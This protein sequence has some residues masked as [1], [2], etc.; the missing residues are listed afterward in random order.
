MSKM[1]AQVV[2]LAKSNYFRKKLLTGDDSTGNENREL[3]REIVEVP[4]VKGA[5]GSILI[6]SLYR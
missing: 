4:G 2:L 1:L 5:V 6:S 3:N